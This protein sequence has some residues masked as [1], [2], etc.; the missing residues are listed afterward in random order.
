MKKFKLTAIAAL[1][2]LSTPLLAQ[3]GSIISSVPLVTL[4]PEQ[5]MENL[6]LQMPDLNYSLIDYFTYKKY[7]VQAVK[8]IYSTIDG[9]GCATEASGVV[10]LP[11][12]ENILR[13]PVFAYLHGTLTRDL[14]APSNLIGIESVV[15]WIMAMDG[16]IAI[17]PDYLGIGDGPGLHP[18]LHA[19]SEASASIDMIKAV[20]ALC[21]SPIVNSKPDGNLYLCGY[22]QGAHA[23]LSTQRELQ[24]HPLSGLSLRKT[25]AGSGAYS[26]SKIQKKFLFDHPEYPNPSFIPYLLL[27]YQYIYGNLYTNLSQVFVAPYYET[28]PGLFNGSLTVEEIDSQLP[29]DWTSMFV[30]SYL[31]NFK[32]KYFHPV[33][34]ALR[35]NDVVNWKPESDLHMYYCTCDEQ[36]ANENSL[37]A[38]L[39]FLLN[40]SSYVTCLPVGPFSHV[41]C[42]P[43]VLLLAKIQSDCASGINPCG[44]TKPLPLDITKSSAEVD[45]SMFRK[46]LRG[47]ETLEL[48]DVYANKEISEFLEIE[49]QKERT[50]SIYPNPAADMVYIEIPDEVSDNSRICVYNMLGNLMFS[51]IIDRSIISIDVSSF[52]DGLYKVIIFGLANYSGTLLVK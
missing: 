38:Y 44:F 8:I 47:Y 18:Y 36:V 4:T 50:L 52:P 26:L 46:S 14:D 5:I 45:L 20:M 9:K 41:D 24:T 17:E 2:A 30:P 21:T 49:S 31:W 48:K 27:G 6:K 1:F 40:G 10:F 16:Y 23:A 51:K 33:N 12:V 39:M 13:M 7:S 22:S 43:F 42:A 34:I 11:V 15:G 25:I 19:D 32:Y 3:R 37:L 29:L 35:D 28:I